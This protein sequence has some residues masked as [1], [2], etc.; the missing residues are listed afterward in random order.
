MKSIDEQ[1]MRK[2]LVQ[3][4]GV[5]EDKGL[6]GQA[7]GN[8][9]C[10]VDG[11]MLISCSGATA[12]NLTPARVV[13]VFDDLSWEGEVKPSSEWRMHHGIYQRQASANAVV[14]T[15]SAYCVALACN[16]MPLPG[17]HYMVGMFGGSDVPCVPYSTFGTEQLAIDA[18]E[19]LTDRSACLLGSH[20]MICRGSD[21]EVA[22]SHAERLE[23]LC[24]HYLLARQLGEPYIL[25]ENQWDEFFDQA[26]KLAYFDLL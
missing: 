8:I 21:F 14:H 18:G 17:F 12:K 23:T 20:G 11:G 6:M 2:T 19:A 5:L 15:H 9:S 16:N 24:K 22:I 4:Y 10:R 26:K 7:S 13:K 3:N 1:Q 25:S